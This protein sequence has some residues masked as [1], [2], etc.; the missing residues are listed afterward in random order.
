MEYKE[1]S[2]L[3][4]GNAVRVKKNLQP[5]GHYGDNVF[6]PG[7]SQFRGKRVRIK[8]FVSYDGS[9][10]TIVESRVEY[11]FTPEMFEGSFKF[12]K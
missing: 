3:K 7:M 5:Y 12:G 2:K 1:F 8:E 10:I 4:P 11:W 6:I 9:Q